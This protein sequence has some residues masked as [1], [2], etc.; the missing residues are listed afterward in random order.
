M[1]KEVADQ[2]IANPKSQALVVGVSTGT[3]IDAS[4]L[5]WLPEMVSLTTGVLGIVLTS[6]MI[7]RTYFQISQ[8][9]KD[10]KK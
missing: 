4:I 8:I 7:V 2:V 10:M 1:K 9:K 5:N 6:L 3:A